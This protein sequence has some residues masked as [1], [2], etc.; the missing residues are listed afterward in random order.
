[1]ASEI[2]EYI[3]MISD[4]AII[5]LLFVQSYVLWVLKKPILETAQNSEV[6]KKL[7][8]IGDTKK[9]GYP[10]SL[11]DIGM[12]RCSDPFN[13]SHIHTKDCF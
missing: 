1:L 10:K 5:F 9:T 12:E 3:A 13:K 8:G 7:F 11:S 6:Y 2:L 4:L